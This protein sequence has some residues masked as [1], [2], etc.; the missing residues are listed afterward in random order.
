M[1]IADKH[2][3]TQ[4]HYR[5]LADKIQCWCSPAMF[6]FFPMCLKIGFGEGAVQFKCEITSFKSKIEFVCAKG[7]DKCFTFR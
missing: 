1:P 2:I 3:D 6:E 4:T 5:I 7:S